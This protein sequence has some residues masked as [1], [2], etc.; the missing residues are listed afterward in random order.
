METG[1]RKPV[2]L[3]RMAAEIMW[4]S[5]AEAYPERVQL[6]AEYTV[7]TFGDSAQLA[8]VLL[9]EVI[10]GCKRATSTVAREFL[11]DGQPLPRIGSHWI[12]CDGAGIPRVILQSV[13]LRLGTFRDADADF[14]AAEGEDDKSLESWRRE[15][16]KY[17]QRTEAQK[18]RT[19]DQDTLLVFEHFV[20]VWPEELVEI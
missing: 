7:E 10:H 5:Y 9:H 17:W 16:A 19:W 12:A 1:E 2:V 6:S 15:H 11:D 14:A 3:D 8:N 13:A 4:A 18:G 20:P